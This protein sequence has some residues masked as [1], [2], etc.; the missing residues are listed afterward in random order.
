[1]TPRLPLCAALAVALGCAPKP[2]RREV[3]IKDLAF[4]P[5]M[6][7]VAVGDTLVWRNQDLFPHT[8]TAD[9]AAGWDTGP[10]PADSTRSAVARRPGTF[11]YVCRV[12]PT[13]RGQVVVR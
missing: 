4:V 5:A 7:V 11:N 6:M 3:Q 1:M 10:I 12:H 2:V 13:M 9:G 8:A